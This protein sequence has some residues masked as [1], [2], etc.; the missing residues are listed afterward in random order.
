MAKCDWHHILQSEAFPSCQRNKFVKLVL[1]DPVVADLISMRY[2]ITI[3]GRM[4]F[5]GFPLLLTVDSGAL[6][7]VL[8]PDKLHPKTMIDVS[9]AITIM[10]VAENATIESAG[11]VT[12]DLEMNGKLFAHEFHV[13]HE[14]FHAKTDGMVGGDFLFQYGA[15]LDYLNLKLTLFPPAVQTDQES[16]ETDS[17]RQVEKLPEQIEDA[18][19][20]PKSRRVR[21]VT[22]YD[23]LDDER[24]KRYPLVIPK[25]IPMPKPDDAKDLID[26]SGKLFFEDRDYADIFNLN[27][28]ENDG[29]NEFATIEERINYLLQNIRLDHCNA[30]ERSEIEKMI[31]EFPDIFH[32]KGDPLSFTNVAEH[33]IT[34]K[35]NTRPVFTRQYKVP[36]VLVPEM[37]RQI[38]ELIQN[39]IVEPSISNL[40]SPILLVPKQGGPDGEKRHRLVVDFRRINELTESEAFPMP[41]WEEEIAKMHGSKYFSTLDLHSAFHQILLDEESRPIT[42]F[43]TSKRKFQFK[44]M[45]FGLK[46]SPIAW[47]RTINAVLGDLLEERVMSYMDDII[48]YATTLEEH[49]RTLRK[50]FQ[51][52]RECNLK[53]KV[54]KSSFLCK[55]VKYLGHCIDENGVSTNPEKVECIRNFPRPETLTG[56]QSFLGMANYF[57]RYV[58]NYARIARPLHD[59]CKKDIPFVWSPSCEE[60][61]QRLKQAVTLS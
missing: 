3:M 43:Q 7:S 51:R 32:I 11:V 22:Y 18:Q 13:M 6:I 46:G 28:I 57:R 48:T 61:F 25:E 37:N 39:D 50:I 54:E 45:P 14:S 17:E 36:Q 19:R 35:P 47:Q 24:N 23:E 8:K 31:T 12:G 56:V 42:S 26:F 27:F 40:N 58:Q 21:D 52:F 55:K 38:D 44:R 5:A 41:D 10:G 16:A 15:Q 53:L 33:V 59:L 60:A 29:A 49:L 9:R 1:D 30:D 2:E 4:S 34:L 20:S